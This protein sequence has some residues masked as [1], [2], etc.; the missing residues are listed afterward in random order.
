MTKPDMDIDWQAAREGLKEK[1][2]NITEE[3]LEYPEGDE[4]KLMAHLQEKTGKTREELREVL[5]RYQR[6]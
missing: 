4:E 5:S 3:D 1:Y 6:T 2:A